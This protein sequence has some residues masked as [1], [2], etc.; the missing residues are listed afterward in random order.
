VKRKKQ[1]ERQNRQKGESPKGA[2]FGLSPF[3][4]TQNSAKSET[5][6][7]MTETVSDVKRAKSARTGIN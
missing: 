3:A 7:I 1:R 4:L 6:Y 5:A 2:A